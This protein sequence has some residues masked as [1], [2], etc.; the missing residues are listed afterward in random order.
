MK[1]LILLILTLIFVSSCRVALYVAIGPQSVEE[2]EFKL[3]NQKADPNMAEIVSAA[4]RAAM[5]IK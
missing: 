1:V 2:A 3:T 5:G 4:V